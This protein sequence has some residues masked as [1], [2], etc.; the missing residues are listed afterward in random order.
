VVEA[1]SADSADHRIEP[2]GC[3]AFRSLSE[4]NSIR[5]SRR[6]HVLF[7]RVHRLGLPLL[8]DLRFF[9][10]GLGVS[11]FVIRNACPN[12]L[13]FAPWRP[14]DGC[15]TVAQKAQSADVLQST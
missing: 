13:N 7:M 15:S 1:L 12:I 4:V 3:G 11:A 9:T 10:C 5:V 14:T 8:V 2:A 6:K